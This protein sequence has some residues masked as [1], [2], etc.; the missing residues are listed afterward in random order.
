[1]HFDRKT[2]FDKIRLAP[3]PGALSPA[4]VAGCD[5]I[6]AEFEQRG[7]TDV[8]WLA[9]MQ[10]TAFHE[11]AHTMQPINEIGR[12]KGHK[13]GN[14]VNGKVYYGRGYVQ[15]TW[16]YNYKKMG[17]LLHVDLLG[18]P[19]LAL[20]PDIAAKIMFE[21][22]IRGSFTGK[23]L[24][25]YIHDAVCDFTNARRIINGL[26]RAETIAVASVIPADGP[27]FGMAPSGM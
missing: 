8:R 18:N 19:E 24:S 16:D 13:Y 21:G 15:L 10:A 3:F 27:S 17:D 23:K 25:D 22:M 1:M 2:F 12:G 26:D 20:K 11:T 4:Q 9:Y 7:L 5:A 6:I 14:P